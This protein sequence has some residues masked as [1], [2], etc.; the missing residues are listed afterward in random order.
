MEYQCLNFDLN[1]QGSNLLRVVDTDRSK[2][3]VHTNAAE[4][5]RCLR[6]RSALNILHSQILWSAHL[7]RHTSKF[8]LCIPALFRL[9][10]YVI[11]MSS[12][13]SQVL[14]KCI[15]WFKMRKKNLN[16]KQ[17]IILIDF[18]FNGTFRTSNIMINKIT[19]FDVY[20]YK[21]YLRLAKYLKIVPLRT[22]W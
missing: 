15:F 6:Y 18:Y 3:I 11:T 12:S 17:K 7:D 2:E 10:K 9:L 21:L 20:T 1:I 4:M 14:N 8:T 5:S 22:C 16:R 19:Y 13:S